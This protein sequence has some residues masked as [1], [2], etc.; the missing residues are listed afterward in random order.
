MR[1]LVRLSAARKEWHRIFTGLKGKNVQPRICFP[2]RLEEE[3]KNFSD[4]QKLEFQQY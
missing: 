2:A 3:M 1:F 4:K